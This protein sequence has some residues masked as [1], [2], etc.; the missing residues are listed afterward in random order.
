MSDVPRTAEEIQALVEFHNSLP[1]DKRL[2]HDPPTIEI[3]RYCMECTTELDPFVVGWTELERAA[4]DGEWIPVR[5]GVG[6]C[7]TCC[8]GVNDEL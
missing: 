4:E 6:S 5:M 2:L 1:E 3:T 8:P 7:V